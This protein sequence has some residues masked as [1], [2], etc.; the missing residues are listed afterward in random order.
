[1]LLE[2]NLEVEHV[3]NTHSEMMQGSEKQ[4]LWNKEKMKE[5]FQV[6]KKIEIE[7]GIQKMLHFA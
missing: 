6:K 7:A 5:K 2:A 4:L 1:M 3:H